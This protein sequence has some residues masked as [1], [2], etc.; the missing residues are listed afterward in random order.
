M[1]TSKFPARTALTSDTL[2]AE[3]DTIRKQALIIGAGI[4]GI[5]Q[6]VQLSKAGIDFLILE[7]AHDVGGAWRE[8]TYPGAQADS[9]CYL[10][11]YSHDQNPAWSSAFPAQPEMLIYLRDVARRRGLFPHIRFG[12]EVIGAR[13]DDVAQEWTVSVAGGPD[14][15]CQF[16]IFAVG[17]WHVPH[18]PGLPGA[19]SFAGHRWHSA[20]W[21]HDVS[22]TGK[23]VA[24]IGTGGSGVQLA[25]YLA[26]NA[27]ELTIFQRTPASVLPKDDGPVPAWRQRMFRWLPVTQSLYRLRIYL[28][29]EKVVWRF[30][31]Q[32]DWLPAAELRGQRRLE[33]QIGN[34]ELRE[35]LTPGHHLGCKQVVF[36]NDFYQ[37]VGRPHVHLAG[38]A[39]ALRPQAVVDEDGK[40]WPADAVIYATGFDITGSF[41]RITIKGSSGCLLTDVWRDGVRSYNGIL[42]P[43]FPN[44]FMLDGPHIDFTCRFINLKA[45]ARFVIRAIRMAKSARG[46]VLDVR[47]EAER[48]FQE[49]VRQKHEQIAWSAGDCRSWDQWNARTVMTYWPGYTWS[50]RQTLRKLRLRDFIIS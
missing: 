34:P 37:T 2:P 7:K 18:V 6:A 46:S 20:S 11:S 19:D 28:R 36:S 12:T 50:Y 26:E 25:P 42:V 44:M 41:N 5:G 47:P 10:Y 38:P 33:A 40:E 3:D 4:A 39:V 35:K 31:H 30:Y 22:L 29:R 24:L 9:R 15:K 21:N 43:G 14:H 13:W 45:Q 1:E 27:S 48:R 49:E 17:K 16:L 23:R 32:S 8:N